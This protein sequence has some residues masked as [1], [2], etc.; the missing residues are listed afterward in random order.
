M[1]MKTVGKN[2]STCLFAVYFL[3]TLLSFLIF[4]SINKPLKSHT[5]NHAQY[6][7]PEKLF[8]PLDTF[9]VPVVYGGKDVHKV[10]PPHSYI[11]VRDFK[12][13][14]HLAKYLLYLDKND[15]EYMSY[16]KWKENY[17]VRLGDIYSTTVFCQLCEY[18]F[19][20]ST[21]K[22]YSSFN[23]WFFE[24]SQ[25]E[26]PTTQRFFPNGLIRW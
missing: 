20:N 4:S 10:A 24:E 6:F 22:V 12:S 15:A 26:N 19:T 25:C 5:N 7:I 16:F 3:Q 8:R 13:P 17:Q 1:L 14:K 23:S 18:L 11:D 9:V 2:P 21:R